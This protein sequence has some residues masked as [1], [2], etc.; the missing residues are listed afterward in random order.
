MNLC[1][2]VQIG[3]F[4]LVAACSAAREPSDGP[5]AADGSD[6]GGG[7]ADGGP[8]PPG[9]RTTAVIVGL[10]V[11]DVRP[12]I[13]M[14]LE[15]VHVVVA[16]DGAPVADENVDLRAGDALPHETKLQAPKGKA[17]AA[18][19]VTVEGFVPAT[20]GGSPA[21]N[22][23]RV[24][25]TH[26][27][28]SETRLLPIRLE[29]RCVSKGPDL[30]GGAFFLGPTCAAPQTCVAGACVS[31]AVDAGRLPPYTPT[32]Q[33]DMPDACR[34][35]APTVAL[36]TGENDF[37]PLEDGATVRLV[38]GPQCGHHIWAGVKMAGARQ[39]DARTTFSS[40]QPGTALRGPDAAFSFAYGD[41]GGGTCVLWGVRYQVDAV[42]GGTWKDLLGKPLDLTVKVADGASKEMTKTVHV[43]VDATYDK[44]PRPCAF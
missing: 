29:A 30:V 35:S 2:S 8:A 22:V 15:R 28:P 1:R 41:G 34:A 40:A 7:G 3:S 33:K 9:D 36:G 10:D 18:I 14:A 5:A 27:S 4:V 42:R 16:V 21:P 20:G 17:D 12:M 25:R 11:E 32:W 37:V 39:Y 19:D 13:G 38:E 31:D 26:F 43:N 23:V 24:A 44:A 6:A